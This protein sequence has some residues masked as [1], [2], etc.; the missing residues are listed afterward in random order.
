[1]LTRKQQAKLLAKVLRF[2]ALKAQHLRLEKEYHIVR[3]SILED[4]GALTRVELPRDTGGLA[5]ITVTGQ[6]RQ[7]IDQKLLLIDHPDIYDKVSTVIKVRLL[8]IELSEEEE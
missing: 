3:E 1:M 7:G 6:D 5:T 2:H 4:L 8:H